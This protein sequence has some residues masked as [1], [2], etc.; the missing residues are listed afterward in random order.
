MNL[1]HR[2]L[3]GDMQHLLQRCAQASVL[4]LIITGTSVASSQ[5]AVRFSDE[6][7]DV[8]R[9]LG[10]RLWSTAG[11]H[12]HDAKSCDHNT[13]KHLR[14]LLEQEDVVAVGVSGEGLGGIVFGNVHPPLLHCAPCWCGMFLGRC[15]RVWLGLQSHVQSRRGAGGVVPSAGAAGL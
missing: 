5:R 13:I 14:T 11:V 4:G 15:R 2:Q 10:L 1:T 6:W 9:D 3:A 12:P 8:A 7:G